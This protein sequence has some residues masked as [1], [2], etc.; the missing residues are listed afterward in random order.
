[1]SHDD[2]VFIESLLAVSAICFAGGFWIRRKE[3]APG[4]WPQSSGVIVTSKTVRQSTM[5]GQYQV[6][7][8][9]EYAFDYQGHSFKS[10]HWRLSNY[11]KGN[12]ASAEAVTSRYPLGS[13]VTVFVNPKQPEKSV[14]EMTTSSLCW[15]PF[16]LGVFFLGLAILAMTTFQR[17]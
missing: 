9:I 4:R 14:L 12:N 5:H 1:M 3:V 17:K 8:M 10:S 15:V 7:P 11:S 13:A 6:L 16:G 2:K